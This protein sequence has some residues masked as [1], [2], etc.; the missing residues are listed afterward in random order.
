MNL[1]LCLRTFIADNLSVKE[2]KHDLIYTL[3][4]NE[5]WVISVAVCFTD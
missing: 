2:E 1:N 4:K 5:P 3:D